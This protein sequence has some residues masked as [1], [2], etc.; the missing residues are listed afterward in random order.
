M[1]VILEFNTTNLYDYYNYDMFDGTINL[2]WKNRHVYYHV[3]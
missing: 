2:L 3:F 1:S